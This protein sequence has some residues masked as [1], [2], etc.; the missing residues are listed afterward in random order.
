LHPLLEDIHLALVTSSKKDQEEEQQFYA[1]TLEAVTSEFDKFITAN[2]GN[3][4]DEAIQS[5]ID[6]ICLFISNT[7]NKRLG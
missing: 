4:P 3:L 7:T 1:N 6:V 2:Y 5:Y